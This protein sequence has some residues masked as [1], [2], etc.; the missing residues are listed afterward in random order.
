MAIK[1]VTEIF[2]DLIWKVN[3]PLI[4]EFELCSVSGWLKYRH[5]RPWSIRNLF[6]DIEEGLRH[7]V[8]IKFV[9]TNSQKNGVANSLAN[10]GLFRNHFFK[11]Y[12]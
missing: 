4:I 8:E 1:I 6:A 10:V 11:A 5:L 9:V 7:L 12:W 2:I 3:V